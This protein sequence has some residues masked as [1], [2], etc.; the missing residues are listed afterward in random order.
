MTKQTADAGPPAAWIF[1]GRRGRERQHWRCCDAPRAGVPGRRRC[2]ASTRPTSSTPR[3]WR[4]QWFSIRGRDRR[5]PPG[6]RGLRAAALRRDGARA[7]AALRDR[8]AAHRAVRLLA[9]RIMAL[10]AHRPNQAGRPR[11]H[12]QRRYATLPAHAP[13]DTC[14]HLLHG[15]DDT[16]LPARP[17]SGRGAPA[18]AR[19]RRH[20]DV[21]PQG[22]PGSTRASSSVRS[23]S[24]A[25]SCRAACGK[26]A[27]EDA[28]VQST[29]RLEREVATCRWS[30]GAP[31]AL[32]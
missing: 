7:A 29:A 28:P 5:E 4:R 2:C 8:L 23:T 16:V 10:E 3:R 15:L 13:R 12:L 14:V 21:L 6:A 19:R 18:G 31:G 26:A 17:G 22:R 11:D 27:F 32:Q 24:C 20:G 30:A 25:A 1:H 9:G